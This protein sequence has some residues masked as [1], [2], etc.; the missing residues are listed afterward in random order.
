L[1]QEPELDNDKTVREIVEEAR[2]VNQLIQPL[3]RRVG[4]RDVIEQA[5]I[6]GV[7]NLD[8]A[9]DVTTASKAASYIAKRL[10]ALAAETERGWEGKAL[11]PSGYR[12]SR[13]LRGVAAHH[14]INAAL[15]QSAEAR[16]LDELASSL[17]T[18][19]ERH[20]TLYRKDEEIVITGPVSL[21]EVI[22]RAGRK[23]L[24]IQRY[25]GLG[26][27]NPEQLWETT[28]D[29]NARTLLRVKVNHADEAGK[30]FS[31]LMGDVVEPRRDFIQE[32]A[33]KVV[34]LDV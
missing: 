34:N 20:A 16:R 15:I 14:E 21:V 33:L 3:A 7:L 25:K 29:P 22:T 23:G 13:T 26:E 8:F 2:V 24:A 11:K 32:N 17:Q 30:I 28:L 5:A 6:L 9:S 27:M 19:W 12:F 1:P 10:D 4:S 18:T 31:T